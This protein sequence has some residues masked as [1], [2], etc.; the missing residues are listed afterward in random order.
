MKT[1]TVTVNTRF[2]NATPFEGFIRVRLGTPLVGVDNMFVAQL[3]PQ[4][5]DFGG[6]NPEVSFIAIPNSILGEDTYYVVEIYRDTLVGAH[7]EYDIIHTSNI[8]IPDHDCN[9]ADITIVEPIAPEPLEVSKKYASESK[10]WAKEAEGHASYTATLIASAMKPTLTRHIAT[11]DNESIFGGFISTAG[12]EPMYWTI[13]NSAEWFND[14]VLS[15]DDVGLINEAMSSPVSPFTFRDYILAG[16][17]D[18]KNKMATA[19]I[20]DIADS[21]YTRG[22]LTE[23]DIEQIRANFSDTL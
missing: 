19:S 20:L 2:Q 6:G 10:F 23:T 21:W 9:L 1:V 12:I 16:I 14:G 11:F 18:A 15:L 13:L 8:V 4:E 3:N 22:E 7:H 17:N 5:I